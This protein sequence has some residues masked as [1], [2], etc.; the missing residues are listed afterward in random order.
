MKNGKYIISLQFMR[1]LAH[2]YHERTRGAA[3]Y[4]YANSSNFSNDCSVGLKQGFVKRISAQLESFA[5]NF[6][7]KTASLELKGFTYFIVR[8]LFMHQCMTYARFEHFFY[9]YLYVFFNNLVP[10]P[11][12]YNA[13]R[14]HS[15]VHCG[16]GKFK[17]YNKQLRLDI[18]V[19][20]TSLIRK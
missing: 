4:Q 16:F 1:L 3:R 14:R 12:T 19:V 8:L 10:L 9:V 6:R 20:D 2:E 7:H 18:I 5:T 15:N 11:S 17:S 13:K